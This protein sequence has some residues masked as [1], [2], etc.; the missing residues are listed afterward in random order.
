MSRIFGRRAHWIICLAIII[1]AG[2][3][4]RLARTGS[5]LLDK[6][7]GDALYAAMV[8]AILRL[9][10]ASRAALFRAL[11]AVTAIELFQLTLIAEH[12]LKSQF[13]IVRI[14]ARLMGT[15]FSSLDLLAY[16]F[17]IGCMYLADPSR[18]SRAEGG[19]K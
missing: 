1:P 15:H 12:L 11:A 17:A 7:A 2:I 13:L 9:W 3:L 14:I 18:R 10:L 5:V 8:Y 19:A 6:Y 16:F 4:S